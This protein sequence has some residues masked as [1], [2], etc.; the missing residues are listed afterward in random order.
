[1]RSPVFAACTSKEPCYQVVNVKLGN[2]LFHKSEIMEQTRHVYLAGMTF[3]KAI[4]I[5]G[6][7]RGCFFCK[8]AASYSIECIVSRQLFNLK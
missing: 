6:K 8:N 1:V 2:M 5:Q 3:F 7:I 4:V